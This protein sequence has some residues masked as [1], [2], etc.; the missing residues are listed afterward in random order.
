MAGR[1]KVGERYGRLI[2]LEDVGKDNKGYRLWKCKCDCGNETIVPSRYL[3][4]GTLSCGCYAREQSAKRLTKHGKRFSRI[5]TVHNSMIQRCKNPNAHEYENYGGRGISVCDE[6]KDFEAF[7][8]WAMSN[9]Y[10]DTLTL[11]RIDTNGNYEPS[12]CR[13]VPMNTQQRN[14][15]SNV[16]ITHNGETHCMSEWA[17]IAGVAYGT[18]CKRIYAGWSMERAMQPVNR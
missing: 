1:I 9:G 17:E 18:F 7:E 2:T 8:A 11:D 14:R 3:G 16:R 15:R 12:N 5:Y 10:E 6:W 13:F 4:K